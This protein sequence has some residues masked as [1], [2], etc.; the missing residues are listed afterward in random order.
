MSENLLI[1]SAQRGDTAALEKLI[2]NYAS[3]VFNLSFKLMGN[4]SDA[5]DAAQDSL[6]KIHSAIKGFQ[7]KSSFSTWVYR[8]TFNTCMDSQRKRKNNI[9]YE[10]D[11]AIK[12]NNP[13]PHEKAEQNERKELIYKALKSLQADFRSAV[14]LRDIMGNSYEEIAEIS[15]CS[16]GTVKSRINRG[17]EKL[18]ELLF[19]CMEQK[20]KDKRPIDERGRY[21]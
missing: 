21:L 16:I 15:G 12:D 7:K 4:Y 18:R 13:S 9:V 10:L 11:D 3:K 2:V 1:E 14:V 19:E 20:P 8:I 6:I 17:R 5:S